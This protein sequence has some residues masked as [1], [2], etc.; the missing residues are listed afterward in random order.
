M[1]KIDHE[2]TSVM[3][4]RKIDRFFRAVDVRSYALV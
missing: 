3:K 4:L 2:N 1:N